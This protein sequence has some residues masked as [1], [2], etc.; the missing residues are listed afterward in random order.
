MGAV[1]ACRCS[2]IDAD[3]SRST[4]STS[5]VRDA[6]VGVEPLLLGRVD[7][8]VGH[9]LD[10]VGQRPEPRHRALAGLEIAGISNG[11]H[12]DQPAVVVGGHER[13][14]RGGHD[15]GDGRQL[16][17]RGL[18]LGDEGGKHR[19]VAGSSSI[20]PTIWSRGGRRNWK[21]VATP[22]LPPPPRIAQNS[23]GGRSTG[24]NRCS[25]GADRRCC[26][27]RRPGRRVSLLD[28][29]RR[30]RP[31]CWCAGDPGCSRLASPGPAGQR[32]QAI[33]TRGSGT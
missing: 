18:G 1:E 3:P 25:V 10:Q 11:G 16:L 23:S 22:K 32:S 29:P 19:R 28:Q 7:L 24:K 4:A 26:P 27:G 20:P 31:G 13:Q 17:R 33:G 6:P 12:D 2:R 8:R 15:V 30:L 14:R 9:G 5:I 21:R